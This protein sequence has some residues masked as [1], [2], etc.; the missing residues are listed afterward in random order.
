MG[1]VLSTNPAPLGKLDLPAAAPPAATAPLPTPAAPLPVNDLRRSLKR[2]YEPLE[3]VSTT[4]PSDI[5]PRPVLSNAKKRKL[6]A[7]RQHLELRL[8]AHAASAQ[9]NTLSAHTDKLDRILV[10]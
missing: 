2:K 5:L 10:A 1:A 7:A 3:L 8:Q 4:A 9:I 6:R